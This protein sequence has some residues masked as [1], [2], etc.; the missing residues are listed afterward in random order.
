MEST[1]QEYVYCC[2]YI[3][4]EVSHH[5]RPR[6]IAAMNSFL[7]FKNVRNRCIGYSVVSVVHLMTNPTSFPRIRHLCPYIPWPSAY[8]PDNCLIN[9]PLPD[10]LVPT[11]SSGKKRKSLPIQSR[12]ENRDE[13]ITMDALQKQVKHKAPPG[14]MRCCVEPLEESSSYICTR[15]CIPRQPDSVLSVHNHV[16]ST[17]RFSLGSCRIHIT[18]F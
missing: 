6:M 2:A 5:P 11:V 8:F 12:N 18:S 4:G 13:P 17:T 1:I 3:Y 16:T 15:E 14:G 7:V 10:M 9:S